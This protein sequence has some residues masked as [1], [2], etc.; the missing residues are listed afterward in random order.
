M[1]EFDGFIHFFDVLGFKK[2]SGNLREEILGE[3]GL[4]NSSLFTS[5]KLDS[6]SCISDINYASFVLVFFHLLFEYDMF[7]PS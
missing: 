1:Q 6:I 3:D 7:S 2:W 5:D 4:V